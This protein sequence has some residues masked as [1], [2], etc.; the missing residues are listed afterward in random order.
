MYKSCEIAVLISYGGEKAQMSENK[1]LKLGIIFSYITMVA[2][3]VVSVL[4][5]PFL[6][7]SL[8]AQ[9]YGL[10]NMG[11]AAISYL[12][13]AEFGFGNAVVRYSAKYRAE[14]NQGK[15]SAMYGMFMYIYGILSV[16]ITIVGVIICVF[17]DRFYTVS[18]GAQGYYELK[19]IILFM[20]FNL[21]LTFFLQP[22][23]AIITAHERFTFIK[24]TN[25]IYTLLKPVVMIPLLIWGYKAI[26]LSVVTFVL[27]QMLNLAN[28]VY[29]RKVLKVKITMNPK[30]M[31]FSILKE[32]VSYSFFIFLGSVVGQLNDNADTVILG[33]ISGEVAVAVYT[34]GYTINTYVQQIPA[35]VGSVFFPRVTTRITKGASMDDMTDLMIRIGRIQYFIM[36]LMC[37]GFA[38]FGQEFIALWAGEGYEVAYWIVLALVIPAVIPN[39]QTI[40]VLVIQAMNRHQFKAILYVV[41]A[42]LNVVLSIPA[43]LKYGPLGCA[44]CTGIT[45]LITKGIIINCFYASK[46][47]LGIGRFW[48]DITLVTVK[49]LP[50]VLVGVALNYLLPTQGWLWLIAKI[51]LFTVVFLLYSVFVC[52]NK[53]EKSLIFGAVSKVLPKRA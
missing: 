40:P 2:N 47:H 48:K 21:G 3:I 23:S 29:V 42:V 53:E 52:M 11:H 1:N 34:I 41:C 35:V 44:V 27:Q 25:L 6:L 38:I 51:V 10:Y 20:V 19:V 31:D 12:S 4:Y 5:T 46:I 22:Y 37:V 26:A 36:F 13:L 45:T 14:G 8:G 15:T 7:S 33:I 18:T 32:I 16:L 28:M 39:I 30:K 24:V 49:L 43:G 50:T 9:Q 17:S